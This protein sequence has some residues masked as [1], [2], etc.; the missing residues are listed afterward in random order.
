MHS[1]RDIKTDMIQRYAKAYAR[2]NALPQNEQELEELLYAFNHEF[3]QGL[4]KMLNKALAVQRDLVDLSVM[5]PFTI[6]RIS[7]VEQ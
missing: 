3:N 5:P 7:E 4:Q 6:P 1:I 2:N